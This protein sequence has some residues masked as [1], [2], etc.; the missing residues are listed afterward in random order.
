MFQLDNLQAIMSIP[1]DIN[2]IKMIIN[3]AAS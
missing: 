3:T 2:M 1:F